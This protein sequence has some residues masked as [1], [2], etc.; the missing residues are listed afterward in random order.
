ME[1]LDELNTLFRSRELTDTDQQY[2]THTAEILNH[3]TGTLLAAIEHIF[4]CSIEL[5]SFGGVESV[6]GNIQLKL[7]LV[8]L[9]T[10]DIPPFVEREEDEGHYVSY[11]T[12]IMPLQH[13]HSRN[14]CIAALAA[15]LPSDNMSSPV[16][17]ALSIDQHLTMLSFIDYTINKIH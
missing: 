6:D 17:E 12:I 2:K 15:G 14:D 3:L 1:Y 8:Y 4:Q 5:M 16:G 11:V 10:D 9:L 7:K 13:L